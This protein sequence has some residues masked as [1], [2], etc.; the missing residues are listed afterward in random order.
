MVIGSLAAAALR[1]GF[2]SPEKIQ[3]ATPSAAR[4]AMIQRVGF[5]FLLFLFDVSAIEW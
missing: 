1:E 5:A 2:E 3:I 4:P